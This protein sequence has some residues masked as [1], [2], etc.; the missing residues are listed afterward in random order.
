MNLFRYKSLLG[1]VLS[2]HAPGVEE[3][4]TDLLHEFTSYQLLD[5]NTYHGV[6]YSHFMAHKHGV[7]LLAPRNETLH[8]K[9]T[10][11]TK[12]LSFSASESPLTPI[13]EETWKAAFE[14]LAKNLGS[15]NLVISPHALSWLDHSL[16]SS[17]A[18]EL[19]S[20]SIFYLAN[21][22]LPFE[23]NPMLDTAITLDYCENLRRVLS[24]DNRFESVDKEG[25]SQAV[26]HI[27]TCLT[28]RVTLVQQSCENAAPGTI[29]TFCGTPFDIPK[30]VKVLNDLAELSKASNLLICTGTDHIILTLIY[31]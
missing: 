30:V 8:F 22:P 19:M 25:L 4:I 1:W 11:L 17:K 2:K 21:S 10:C 26:S 23:A 18:S 5:K 28:K 20:I 3:I 6:H 13:Q 31:L 9:G 27:H 14:A 24:K 7:E 29:P 16:Y 12:R 15:V